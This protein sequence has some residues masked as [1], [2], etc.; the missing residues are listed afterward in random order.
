MLLM[1]ARRGSLTS[2]SALPVNPLDQ[3]L[4]SAESTQDLDGER[5][6][7]TPDWL[8]SSLRLRLAACIQNAALKC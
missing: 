3:L 2:R 7:G 1:P 8:M 6:D 4:A 5:V